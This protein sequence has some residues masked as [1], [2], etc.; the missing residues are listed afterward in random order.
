MRAPQGVARGHKLQVR[1]IRVVPLLRRNLGLGI[2]G[3]ADTFQ[4]AALYQTGIVPGPPKDVLQSIN[5]LI[6]VLRLEPLAGLLFQVRLDFYA[7]PPTHQRIMTAAISIAAGNE[8]KYLGKTSGKNK[9][10]ATVDGDLDGIIVESL[11]LDDT[12]IGNKR[13]PG[14]FLARLQSRHG[15]ILRIS[16]NDL[17]ELAFDEVSSSNLGLKRGLKEL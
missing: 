7:R 11:L 5:E 3:Q 4:A 14:T 16:F 2:I 17:L 8:G 9:L 15:M 10:L 12:R 6:N 13:E 1:G